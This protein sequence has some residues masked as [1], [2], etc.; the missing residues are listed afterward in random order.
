[1]GLTAAGLPRSCTW[2]PFHPPLSGEPER[3]DTISQYG[4]KVNYYRLPFQ[5]AGVTNSVLNVLQGKTGGRALKR[6][7]CKI[8]CDRYGSKGNNCGLLWGNNL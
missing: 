6:V 4:N 1:M 7:E 2:F 3:E 5:K 8:P